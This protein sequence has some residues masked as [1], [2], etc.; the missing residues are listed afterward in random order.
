MAGRA[1]NIMTPL[2]APIALLAATLLAACQPGDAGNTDAGSLAGLGPHLQ[3]LT[4][5][6]LNWCRAPQTD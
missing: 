6:Q 4:A 5:M 2:R 3:R 1:M